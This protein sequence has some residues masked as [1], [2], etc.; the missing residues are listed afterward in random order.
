MTLLLHHAAAVVDPEGDPE[1][2]FQLAVVNPE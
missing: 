1:Q 2:H